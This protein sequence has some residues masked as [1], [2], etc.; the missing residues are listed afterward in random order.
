MVI[1]P[2]FFWMK[3]K[4]LIILRALLFSFNFSLAEDMAQLILFYWET[5]PH[6]KAE[7]WYLEYDKDLMVIHAPYSNNWVCQRYEVADWQVFKI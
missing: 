4:L 3:K 2:L 6:C 1:Y 5:C 7:E